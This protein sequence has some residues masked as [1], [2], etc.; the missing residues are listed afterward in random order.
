MLGSM[1]LGKGRE[2]NRV[3]RDERGLDEC[4]LNKV[5]QNLVDDLASP[6]VFFD[7]DAKFFRYGSKFIP[8]K[9]TK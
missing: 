1:L 3:I 8:S 4:G 7:R 9:S 5:P 2:L 6:H